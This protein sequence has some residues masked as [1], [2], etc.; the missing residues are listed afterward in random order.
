MISPLTLLIP[1]VVL[2]SLACVPHQEVFQHTAPLH[3]SFVLCD[4][5]TLTVAP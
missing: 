2:A 3:V 4:T 1:D 5:E